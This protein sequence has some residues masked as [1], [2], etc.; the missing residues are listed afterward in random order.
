MSVSLT[1]SAPLEVRGGPRQSSSNGGKRWWAYG[2]A[3]PSRVVRGP[4]KRRKASSQ[5]VEHVAP[6]IQKGSELR[7]PDGRKVLDWL[8]NGDICRGQVKAYE[9]KR[10]RR[11]DWRR[12]GPNVPW[13]M[14][15]F[16]CNCQRA[17]SRPSSASGFVLPCIRSMSQ[18]GNPPRISVNFE[19]TTSRLFSKI[20][21]DS[22]LSA[23]P[24]IT[25]G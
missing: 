18:N 1:R 10:V 20:A 12:R 23:H 19:A 13:P 25:G 14:G 21:E 7:S 24:K 2:T 22:H 8:Y 11:G 6:S 15:A 4:S 16:I 9:E 5:R 3:R 17:L